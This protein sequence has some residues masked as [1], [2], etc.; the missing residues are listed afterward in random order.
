MSVLPSIAAV[1]SSAT[2]QFPS[3]CF[4]DL[5]QF[6]ALRKSPIRLTVESEEMQRGTLSVGS[7][8][9]LSV[10]TA[11]GKNGVAAFVEI[12]SWVGQKI[13][14]VS[15]VTE[16]EHTLSLPLERLLLDT[17]VRAATH[18]PTEP[19]A[20][21][22]VSDLAER[23]ASSLA[24]ETSAYE[25]EPA[26]ANQSPRLDRQRVVRLARELSKID[27]FAALAI[28]DRNGTPAATFGK[29]TAF[30]A[31]D[32]L[33]RLIAEA[34]HDLHRC[35]FHHEGRFEILLL[36]LHLDAVLFIRFEREPVNRGI[37]E[38]TLRRVGCI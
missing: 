34:S 12:L 30:A 24:E 3:T 1:N 10:E 4:V 7:G 27:G 21:R 6:H 29:P 38:H 18:A 36:D 32:W 5:L 14:E 9:V 17:A 15:G 13:V 23:P 37:V 22:P 19:P 28:F 11:S 8:R 26:E 31:P 25:D 33:T 2:R 16:E 35:D 20:P